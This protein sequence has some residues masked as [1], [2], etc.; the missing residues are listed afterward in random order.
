M[1]D[2]LAIDI[3]IGEVKVAGWLPL[4]PQR[5]EV[6][7]AYR[8]ALGFREADTGT[9]PSASA[10]EPDFAAILCAAV[11]LCWGG[12]PLELVLHT[13]TGPRVIVCPPGPTALRRFDRDLVGFGDA[14]LDAL[15]RRGYDVAD[16]YNAGRMTREAMLESI[17]TQAE[18]DDAADF[19]DPVE[20][21]SIGPMQ[22]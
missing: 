21:D 3:E 20:V 19:T 5:F 4:L 13:D 2:G 7:A 22:S 8:R 6:E 10:S 1:V 12:E 11:G 15:V 9:I 17:P 18:V 14:V 16:I